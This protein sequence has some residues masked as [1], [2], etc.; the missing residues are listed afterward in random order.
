M[1]IMNLVI[2]IGNTRTKAA[3]FDHSE[4]IED[5]SVESSPVNLAKKILDKFAGIHY[6][7]ISSVSEPEA[8]FLSYIGKKVKKLI[9]VESTI[10]VPITNLYQ[11]PDTLGK[12]RLAALVGAY[13]IFPD[14]NVLIIDAGT[15]ITYDFLNSGKEYSGGNISPGMEMR[16]K[17]LNQFTGKLPKV[18]A[19]NVFPEMGIDTESAILSGVSNGIIFEMES[20][21]RIFSKKHKD[22]KIILTGGDANF[23]V[24]N[25]KKTIFVVPNLIL[26]GLNHIL[27]YNEKIY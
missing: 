12:D 13:T 23:F 10:P 14:S 6:A 20:Y 4:M 26:I 5:Y 27:Q 1:V 3:V 24:R 18:S 7:I 16:F 25:L 15:A 11:T 17:A 8:D 22:L 21:I 2:D 9:E 19:K